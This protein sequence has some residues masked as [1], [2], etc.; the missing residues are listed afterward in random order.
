ML[1]ERKLFLYMRPLRGGDLLHVFRCE[2]AVS[3]HYGIST[4]VMG[5]T[6]LVPSAYETLF[7]HM[8]Y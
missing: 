5:H 1:Y 2:K 8:P 3:F 6:L 7:V 4:H